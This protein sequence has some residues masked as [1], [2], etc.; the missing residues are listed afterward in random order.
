MMKL[1]K[2]SICRAIGIMAV[3]VFIVIEMLKAQTIQQR[4]QI[5]PL[6]IGSYRKESASPFAAALMPASGP[7]MPKKTIGLYAENRFMLRGLADL[8]GAMTIP[9]DDA[10]FSVSGHYHGTRFFSTQSIATGM[11]IQLS[12]RLSTGIK[13]GSQWMRISAAPGITTITADGGLM[14]AINERVL[15]GIHVRRGIATRKTAEKTGVYHEWI[16][17]IGYTINKQLYLAYEISTA[18]G[19]QLRSTVGLEWKAS[20]N[21]LFRGGINTPMSNFFFNAGRKGKHEMISVGFSS[22]AVLG[23]SGALLME[24]ELE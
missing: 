4:N 3:L 10:L 12:N 9:I 18:S 23:Y 16:A 8:Q 7:F 20:D 1:R 6:G 2:C 21:I 17:G 24:Y 19:N 14:Y 15:W 22:H 11:G 13:I 5:I